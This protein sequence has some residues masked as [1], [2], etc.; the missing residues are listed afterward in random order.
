MSTKVYNAFKVKD[1]ANLWRLIDKIFHKGRANVDK[2]LREHYLQ[3]VRHMD[4]SDKEYIEA[5]EKSD[6]SEANFR[7]YRV[8]DK[9]RSRYKENTV[10][11]EWDTYSLDC[12]VCI[13]PYRDQFYL[14]TFC[15]G[16]SIFRNVLDFVKKL[17]ELEDFHYQN[18]SDRPDDIPAKDWANRRRVWDGISK[19]NHDIGVHLD[20]EICS[21]GCFHLIDPWIH[22]AK[23]WVAN[24]PV[25]PSR[26]EVWAEILRKNVPAFTKV[27]FEDGYIVAQP[28]NVEI[29]KGI[30]AKFW[31]TYIE[32]KQKKHKDLNRAADYVS[33]EHQSESTK[34]VVRSL[35]AQAKEARAARRKRAPK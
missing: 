17:P 8:H 12:T 11:L 5:W 14:R 29:R 28:G 33:F 1:P 24:P 25:L 21:W 34:S 15:E 13:Y 20:L 35:M 19:K 26:E 23:E 22:L 3:K 32:G 7:L 30:N 4:P 31:V 2:T 10:R 18:Q 16:G 9:L 27:T 6:S